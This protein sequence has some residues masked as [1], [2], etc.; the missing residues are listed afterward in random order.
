ME[1]IS[2][3]DSQRMIDALVHALNAYEGDVNSGM[4]S[5]DIKRVKQATAE[6]HNLLSHIKL[7]TTFDAFISE[8]RKHPFVSEII[9]YFLNYSDEKINDK[10]NPVTFVER[11]NWLLK[12]E[13]L[14]KLSLPYT[15]P[16]ITIHAEP[17]EI[18]TTP[19]FFNETWV[20][21]QRSIDNAILDDANR[22]KLKIGWCEG[23]QC[24]VMKDS[25]SEDNTKKIE[26]V[27]IPLN[28]KMNEEFFTY[29]D[30]KKQIVI[31]EIFLDKLHL[32]QVQYE[33]RASKDYF[34]RYAQEIKACLD[35]RCYFIFNI[36]DKLL[37]GNEIVREMFREMIYTDIRNFIIS[38][39][40]VK[41][42][43]DASYLFQFIN[44]KF[45]RGFFVIEFTLQNII[46][47]K[48][49]DAVLTQ[50]FENR[51]NFDITIIKNFGNAKRLS[52]KAKEFKKTTEEMK[53]ILSADI[54]D[55]GILELKELLDDASELWDVRSILSDTEVLNLERQSINAF[56]EWFELSNEYPLLSNPGLIIHYID[57]KA[58]NL[59]MKLKRYINSHSK[60]FDFTQKKGIVQFIGNLIGAINAECNFHGKSLLAFPDVDVDV[61]QWK[62][63][64]EP[65]LAQIVGPLAM[66]VLDSDDIVA[67][68][69]AIK[70]NIV[71]KNAQVFDPRPGV[72]YDVID[73]LILDAFDTKPPIEGNAYWWSSEM[74]DFLASIVAM[75]D[76]AIKKSAAMVDM[77][78]KIMEMLK[79][80]LLDFMVVQDVVIKQIKWNEVKLQEVATAIL[81]TITNPDFQPTSIEN[82]EID[83]T[84]YNQWVEQ[85]SS[86]LK[87]TPA[88]DVPAKIASI[89]KMAMSIDILN[90]RIALIDD[91][92]EVDAEK[93]AMLEAS[94]IKLGT[95]DQ[96]TAGD[97]HWYRSFV[98]DHP[99]VNIKF[100]TEKYPELLEQIYM[101]IKALHPNDDKAKWEK[102]AKLVIEQMI[103]SPSMSVDS[104]VNQIRQQGLWA[105]MEKFYRSLDAK[106][107]KNPKHAASVYL[108]S[109]EHYLNINLGKPLMDFVHNAMFKQEIKQMG[110]RLKE[111]ANEGLKKFGGQMTEEGTIMFLVEKY[112]ESIKRLMADIINPEYEGPLQSF[113]KLEAREVKDVISTCYHKYIEDG[114]SP[115]SMNLP[116]K[117]PNIGSVAKQAYKTWYPS[118]A[119]LFKA[120]IKDAN[121]KLIMM[122]LTRNPEVQLPRVA[123]QA[124]KEVMGSASGLVKQSYLPSM[125][126]GKQ[127]M[128]WSDGQEHLHHYFDDEIDA[129]IKR[130]AMIFS[131]E[132]C[133]NCGVSLDLKARGSESSKEGKF[134]PNCAFPLI[135]PSVITRQDIYNVF[136]QYIAHRGG[137]IE[138]GMAKWV[139]KAVVKG[140]EKWGAKKTKF[141]T[142]QGN[143]NPETIFAEALNQP[144]LYKQI[145]EILM[146]VEIL[147]KKM[148]KELRSV[149]PSFGYSGEAKYWRS[150]DAVIRERV[151]SNASKMIQV[152]A[153]FTN[154]KYLHKYAGII[155]HIK[156]DAISAN[157][158]VSN[159]IKKVFNDVFGT[160]YVV[161][162]DNLLKASTDISSESLVN[163]LKPISVSL[164]TASINRIERR[165]IAHLLYN[166]AAMAAV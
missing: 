123:Y 60:T 84:R 119:E 52:F 10:E 49:I 166:L 140:K 4:F 12:L 31:S 88:A 81:K 121:E 32:G 3:L 19:G 85:I 67:R 120:M 162:L 110:S 139:N 99:F 39:Q 82:F 156:Q 42:N 43:K 2:A 56:D 124:F 74:N 65:M 68:L 149:V 13:S 142:M 80:G 112:G 6:I 33:W 135:E 90:L 98:A 111:K 136:K 122:A 51:F 54:A 57:G 150:L 47:A 14:L 94:L 20:F 8:L 5:D 128:S 16:F 72:I 38:K 41:V 64:P 48:K 77:E 117:A 138:G 125:V 144:G 75:V 58:S 17:H 61:D 45:E 91:Q 146:D 36:A 127:S 26:V 106:V 28:V 104:K 109:K 107:A 129:V 1:N 134:C 147:L 66:V 116:Y 27:F 115:K 70:K 62:A 132:K 9:S 83:E 159:V 108:P 100:I 35:N 102:F 153:G 113:P 34:D 131:R 37:L 126:V 101:D 29:T 46:D 114:S 92:F 53:W 155:G 141:E 96:M 18:P 161:S 157:G 95:D 133:L 44:S 105:V 25:P 165:E 23:A 118:F 73:E 130:I 69:P 148:M 22:K 71:A 152:V 7:K 55:L 137:I 151:F 78:K 97:E 76:D 154:D 11:K 89:L 163:F 30:A 86:M 15:R 158:D 143:L 160:N 63:D 21:Q 24:K 93:Y 79:K 87:V 164:D 40:V 145:D 103:L 59:V 50:Y